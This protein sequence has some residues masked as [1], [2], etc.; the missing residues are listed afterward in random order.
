M[1]QKVV[2]KAFMMILNLKKPYRIIKK[3]KQNTQNYK[4]GQ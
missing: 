3:T 1:K 2:P 4:F